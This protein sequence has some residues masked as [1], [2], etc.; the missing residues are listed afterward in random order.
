M[1]VAVRVGCLDLVAVQKRET[2]LGFAP[3]G[4]LLA[5]VALLGLNRDPFDVVLC[6]HRMLCLANMHTHDV[7]LDLVD[8]HVL[9][10]R[11]VD[12][13]RHKLRHLLVAAHD[14]R[15]RIPH[16]R[17]GVPALIALVETLVHGNPP[18]ISKLSADALWHLLGII[19]NS[20]NIARI[21]S[22]INRFGKLVDNCY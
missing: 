8:G 7:A 5:L 4:Q 9:L 11:R 16:E 19:P 10:R 13:A 14:R 6:Q 17:D 18:C 22:L 3:G 15:A 1:Q 21:L 20:G 2:R 12:G